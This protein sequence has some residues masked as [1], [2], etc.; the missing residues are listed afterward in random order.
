MTR[1]VG[2]AFLSDLAISEDGIASTAFLP[3]VCIEGLGKKI[4][5]RFP[6]EAEMVKM[7]CD[8]GISDAK[9]NHPEPSLN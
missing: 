3:S 9:V 1:A 4:S 5:V 8:A 6:D 7:G 2:L